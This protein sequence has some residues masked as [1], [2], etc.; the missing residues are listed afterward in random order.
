MMAAIPT[1][2]MASMSVWFSPAMIDGLASGKTHVL[3]EQRSSPSRERLVEGLKAKGVHFYEYEPVDFTVHSEAASIAFGS[4]VKPAYKFEKAKAILS[5]DCDFLGTEESAFENIGGFAAGRRVK[6]DH[7]ENPA[8]VMNRLYSVEGLL[9]LTGT[10]ADH[11]LRIPTGSVGRVAALALKE[12]IEQADVNAG[13]IVD[14]L[15]TFIEDL[16]KDFPK[17]H[18]VDGGGEADT[19]KWVHECVAVSYTHLTLPTNREV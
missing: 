2:A 12:A 16:N 8:E 14:E 9:S 11:R 1:M 7:T 15:E 3:M 5:L 18:A 4:S 19:A 6:D 17:G 13:E 10:N